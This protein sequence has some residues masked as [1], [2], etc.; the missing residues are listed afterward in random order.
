VRVLRHIGPLDDCFA[1]FL[2]GVISHCGACRLIELEARAGFV[3]WS[4]SF[5]EFA[6]GAIR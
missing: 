6:P 5:R 1:Q 3:A 4:V 2:T